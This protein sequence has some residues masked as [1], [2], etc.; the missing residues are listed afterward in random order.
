VSALRFSP[1]VQGV[2]AALLTPVMLGAA[3]VLGKLAI[4][5]GADP[6]SV[7]A[8]RTAI[9]AGLLWLIYS[10]FFR[11]YLFIYPA[12]LLGCI[13]VGA[14]NGV[15]SLFFYS[16]LGRL[17]AS[18]VQLL[19]G[20]YLIFAVVLARVAGE[21][22]GWRTLTRVGLA[23]VGL[24]LITGLSAQPVDWLGVGLMLASALMFA[25]TLILSQ[26]V[27]YEMPAQTA[28]LYILTTMAVV[29]A[30]VWA[31]VGQPVP[32]TAIDLALAPLIVLGVTTAFSRLALFASVQ[33]FGSLRTAIIAAL[34]IV[35]ALA[36]AF[37]VLGDRLTP[38]QTVGAALLIVSLLLVRA[39]DL[40]PRHLNLNTLLVRDVAGVQFQRIA[41]HRAFGTPEQD[42]E[43]GIMGQITT[44]ELQ[45]I[46][47]MMGAE[48]V[49]NPF[50]ITRPGNVS[51]TPDE[52]AAFLATDPN[53]GD[54]PRSERG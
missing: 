49:V 8:I 15:G 12:G 33:A 42:N 7:A 52:L 14:V 5:A 3:P 32:A 24:V 26:Y 41:F 13:V 47:K 20:T 46:Q 34:E 39:Q 43:F 53:D 54:S 31:G 6:F 1:Q 40:K 10:L 17:D 27:L 50:P 22:L 4:Q 11:R 25:G 48:G 30:V 38:A 2:T 37:I 21:R 44:A 18:M 9:A 23:T 16:G 19:N 45:A 28:A 29:V 36:L 51:L 35:V